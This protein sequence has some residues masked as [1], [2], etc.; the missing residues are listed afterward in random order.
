MRYYTGLSS[1]YGYETGA[2]AV[3]VKLNADTVVSF[4]MERDDHS[5]L[6]IN[7]MRMRAMR[8]AEKAGIP[9]PQMRVQVFLLP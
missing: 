6:T 4:D 5:T 2:R 3:V 1:A 9:T 8:A 7:E